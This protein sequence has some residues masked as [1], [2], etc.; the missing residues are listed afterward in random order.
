MVLFLVL[1][2]LAVECSRRGRLGALAVLLSLA[3]GAAVVGAVAVVVLS[4]L[5]VVA[6]SLRAHRGA[7]G[8]RR[9]PPPLGH[10]PATAAR[11]PCTYAS[12]VLAMS[13]LSRCCCLLPFFFFF[14][15]LSLSAD[16][17]AA[18]SPGV[19]LTLTGS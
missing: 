16:L 1:L 10:T 6:P 14:F 12:S 13:S 15:F 18:F 5:T 9:A 2:A 11:P 3:R 19:S 4:P 8:Q 17:T 7:A